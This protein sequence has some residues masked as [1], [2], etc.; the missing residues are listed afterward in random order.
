MRRWVGHEWGAT[1]KYHT[2]IVAILEEAYTLDDTE[3]VV[4]DEWAWCNDIKRKRISDP[5]RNVAQL[6]Y[7]SR[8]SSWL[9]SHSFNTTVEKGTSRKRVKTA[10]PQ[11]RDPKTKGAPDEGPS[12]PSDSCMRE[13][14]SPR[15]PTPPANSSGP[16]PT[17]PRRPP[18][19]LQERSPNIVRVLSPSRIGRVRRL[20][21]KYAEDYC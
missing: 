18:Q 8:R 14:G 4:F 17:P 20:P 12:K 2:E 6:E 15:H 1:R 7:D 10:A 3:G 19:A 21:S 5:D 9:I 11:V 16:K 13:G